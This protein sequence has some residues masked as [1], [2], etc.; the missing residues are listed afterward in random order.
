MKIRT[1]LIACLAL[2]MCLPQANAQ[3]KRAERKLKREMRKLEQQMEK[4]RELQED[5]YIPMIEELEQRRY[6]K[7]EDLNDEFRLQWELTE[8]DRDR[9]RE[10]AERAREEL[11]K[12][13]LETRE[14]FRDQQLKMREELRRAYEVQR[15]QM[16]EFR[17]QF[18]DGI[19]FK[20]LD[21][22][23]YEFKIPDID[24]PEF[25]FKVPAKVWTVPEG[26][27]SLSDWYDTENNLSINSKLDA[28]SID[29][30]YEFSV[31][32][33]ASSL[34]LKAS[35]SMKTGSIGII[36]SSPDNKEFQKIDLNNT[37]DVD[38]SQRIDLKDENKANLKGKWTI[39]V[40]GSDATG[41][42]KINLRSR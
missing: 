15:D 20:D 31:S 38:W 17:H 32:D 8:R 30:T 40:K 35:G 34:D 1:L 14:Q 13:Q 36:I 27:H 28:E 12:A 29:K 42:Y 21:L 41:V 39:R 2:F 22:P 33:D 18:P 25:N 10:E 16:E 3:S 19:Q 7:F 26:I 9:I 37:A 11:R 23:T 4:V 6:R 5:A 24:L